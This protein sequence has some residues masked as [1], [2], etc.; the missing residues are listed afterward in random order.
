MNNYEMIKSFTFDEM[1]SFLCRRTHCVDCPMKHTKQCNKEI[2]KCRD[3]TM[4]WLLEENNY[5]PK[6]TVSDDMTL[7]FFSFFFALGV[8]SFIEKIFMTFKG[9]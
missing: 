7:I 9:T 5:K 4:Q 2:S 3:K 8:T 6:L 1:L